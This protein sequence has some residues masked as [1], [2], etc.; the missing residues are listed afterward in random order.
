MLASDCFSDWSMMVGDTFDW[1]GG[2]YGF[3]WFNSIF[4]FF[5]ADYDLAEPNFECRP[6][7]FECL[8]PMSRP[9]DS[10]GEFG[11]FDRDLRSSSFFNSY[12][13]LMFSNCSLKFFFAAKITPLRLVE[14]DTTEGCML[15][16]A[17]GWVVSCRRLIS[18]YSWK[19]ISF[20]SDWF[21]W[22][23]LLSVSP[24]D[25]ILKSSD[26]LTGW[27]ASAIWFWFWY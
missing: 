5:N 4:S 8:S 13:I 18:F 27:L 17:L 6:L 21:Y 10:I 15:M 12:L 7:F 11:S 9:P 22:L 3:S 16:A 2:S 1:L 14:V 19:S 24:P 20:L 26:I 25:L 23:W